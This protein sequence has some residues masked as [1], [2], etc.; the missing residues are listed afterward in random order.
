[1]DTSE[2]ILLSV[3]SQST[4][5]QVILAQCLAYMREH[6]DCWQDGS[7]E[8]L[9]A[10]LGWH[11]DM[12][13]VSA[14][15]DP[16]TAGLGALLVVRYIERPESFECTYEHARGAQTAVAE[17]L[18]VTD[19]AALEVAVCALINRLGRPVYLMHSRSKW[20]QDARPKT[21]RWIAFER[22]LRRLY[23]NPK[24]S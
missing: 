9:L 5:K 7:D 24:S 2:N 18:I 23:A 4:A 20:T 16:A 13:L 1:L 14:V 22:H 8:D 6:L 12:G 3:F 17:L 11:W 10:W 19:P 21:V 15:V